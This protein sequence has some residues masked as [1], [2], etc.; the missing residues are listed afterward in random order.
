LNGEVSSSWNNE[1]ASEGFRQVSDEQNEKLK[2]WMSDLTPDNQPILD[3][4]GGAGNLSAQLVD[5]VPEIHCVDLST[6]DETDNKISTHFYYH[7]SSVEPWLG[8]QLANGSLK[9]FKNWTAFIDP[10]ETA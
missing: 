7:R 5:R 1:H 6:P 2:K 3:L 8:N 10:P 4:F 9:H